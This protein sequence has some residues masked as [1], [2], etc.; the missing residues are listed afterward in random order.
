M[1]LHLQNKRLQTKMNGSRQWCSLSR[2]DFVHD[3]ILYYVTVNRV[4]VY[5]VSTEFIIEY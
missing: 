5:S 3:Y 1:E 2:C 4:S